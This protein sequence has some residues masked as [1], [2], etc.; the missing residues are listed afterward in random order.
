M[1]ILMVHV[2]C[3]KKEGEIKSYLFVKTLVLEGV[4]EFMFTPRKCGGESLKILLIDSWKIYSKQFNL[5]LECRKLL[6]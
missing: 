2:K 5:C 1:G 3:C 6:P 4:L